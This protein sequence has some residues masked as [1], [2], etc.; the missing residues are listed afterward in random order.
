[1]EI[2]PN[3]DLEFSL[4]S[5]RSIFIR[6]LHLLACD[7]L[8]MLFE[9]LKN[10]FDLEDSTSGFPQL[11]Q[12]CSHVVIGHILRPIAQVF[13]VARLLALAKPFGSIQLIIVGEI[14]YWLVSRTLCLQ[15]CDTFFIHLSLHQFGVVVKGPCEVVIHNI[16]ITLDVHID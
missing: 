5:F 10:L 6:S 9:H 12:V 8:S 14:L 13:G 16:R 2:Q 4:D 3:S 7:F 11:F 15:F 1:M